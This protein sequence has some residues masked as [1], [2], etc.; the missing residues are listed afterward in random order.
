MSASGVGVLVVRLW[1]ARA[2]MV[3]GWWWGGAM[4]AGWLGGEVVW[5]RIGMIGAGGVVTGTKLTAQLWPGAESARDRVGHVILRVADEAHAEEDE[6][7]D[8]EPTE[9]ELVLR[10]SE[11]GLTLDCYLGWRCSWKKGNP[12][13]HSAQLLAIRK[14][15]KAKMASL[16]KVKRLSLGSKRHTPIRRVANPKK[17]EAKKQ[18]R[19]CAARRRAGAPP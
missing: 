9:A 15:L 12:E 16:T 19:L 3:V 6:E 11:L 14:R 7:A 2:L 8:A 5:R 10:A 13:H 1:L 4:V 18:R 17:E